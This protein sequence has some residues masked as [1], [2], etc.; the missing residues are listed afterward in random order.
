[1]TF[2]RSM[3][4]AFRDERA[5]RPAA[6]VVN[7]RYVIAAIMRKAV[8]IARGLRTLGAWRVR[9]QVALRHVCKLA[10]AEMAAANLLPLQ[11]K[12]EP[13]PREAIRINPARRSAE[14]V[15]PW[16]RPVRVNVHG[17]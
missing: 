15:R 13:A 9:M 12:A 3:L 1:M 6:L 17:W 8:S 11:K 10:K 14:A 4:H 7:S 2:S 16:Y 5:P